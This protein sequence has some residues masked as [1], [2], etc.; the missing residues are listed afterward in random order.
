ME[1]KRQTFEYYTKFMEYLT[2]VGTR[3]RYDIGTMKHKIVES[4]IA[5]QKKQTRETSGKG[6]GEWS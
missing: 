3:N 5:Q 4:F 6:F 1:E 2:L